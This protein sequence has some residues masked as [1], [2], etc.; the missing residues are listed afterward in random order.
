MRTEN[1][2]SWGK[3]KVLSYSF[4]FWLP[5]SQQLLP[6]FLPLKWFYQLPWGSQDWGWITSYIQETLW[7]RF[8][9][10]STAYP[11]QQSRIQPPVCGCCGGVGVLSLPSDQRNM[12]TGGSSR[13]LR[14]RFA[15]Q[16]LCNL[17]WSSTHRFQSTVHHV[18]M[19]SRMWTGKAYRYFI[20]WC[21]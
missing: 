6:I 5:L 17:K 19:L 15:Q 13:P 16:S 12:G 8:I 18:C 10:G 9:S 2:T 3:Q 21:F 11:F 20:I 1:M 7:L 4:C 14:Q